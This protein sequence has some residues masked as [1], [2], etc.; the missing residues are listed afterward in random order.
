M[1]KT[2]YFM[3]WNF[4]LWT[5]FFTALPGLPLMSQSACDYTLVMEDDFG[6]GWNGGALTI[7]IGGNSSVYTL[8]AIDDDGIFAQ[9]TLN[10]MNGDS[11][12]LFYLAGD[13][14]TEVQYTLFDAQ[15]LIVFQDGLGSTEPMQGVVY[16]G[17]IFCPTCFPVMASSV[18]TDE[19]RAFRADIS[20]M[21]PGLGGQYLIEYDTTGFTPGGGNFQTASGAGATLF[22]LEENTP[23]DFYITTLCTN[24][25]TSITVGPFSFHTLYANDVAI[26]G[27]FSPVSACGLNAAEAISVAITNFGGVPQTLIPFDFSVNGIPGGVRMP[28]DGF[29]T[30]VIGTDSTEITEF[31]VLFDFSDFAEYTLQVWT[32]L[33]G[34]SVTSN[35]TTTVKIVNIPLIAEYPYFEGFEEWGGGWTVDA[36]GFGAPSWEYGQP[37]G[38]LIGGAANGAGAWVTNLEGNYNNN[39]ISYLISPCLDFSSLS[40]DPRIA[41][42][43]FVQTENNFD[44]AWLEV[45]TDGGETWSKVGQAGAGLNWYNDAANNWWE[46]NGAVAGWHYAQNI[47]QGT[48]GAADVRARFVFSSDGSV[49][50]EGIGLDNMLIGPVSDYDLAAASVAVGAAGG[51][52]SPNDTVRINLVNLGSGSADTAVVAYSVNGGSPVVDTITNLALLPGG[53][54]AY[55]FETTFDASLA[56][57]YT[58]Q[59]WVSFGLDEFLLNDTVTTFYQTSYT[60]PFREDFESGGIPTGWATSPGVTVAQEHTS[61][62]FVIFDY[63]WLGTTSMEVATPAIGPIE[64]NDTLT[65]DYRYVDYFAGT[66]PTILGLEDSLVVEISIDCGETFTP[67]FVINGN[68]HLPSVS[69]RTV[70]LPLGALTGEIIIIRFRAVWGNGDYYLDLDN[71]NV[72]RCPESLQLTAELTPPSSSSSEDG[73]ITIVAG[74]PSGPFTYLWNTGDATK[75]LTNLAEGVY[76]VTVT[77]VYGCSETL[78]VNLSLNSTRSPAHIGNISLAPNPTRGASV[79]NVEFTKPVDARMQL[80]NTMGQ[81]L[82]ET[83]ERNVSRGAYE[84]DLSRY[85]SGLYLVRIIAEGEVK[86]VKLIKAG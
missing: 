41:F 10:V 12:T 32:A 5:L 72:R 14:P 83:A 57:T 67:A 49:V 13:Y 43:L 7:T 44:E 18:S 66:D 21:P 15:G 76:T 58:I 74:D 25:D 84:L 20:W 28:E 80:L 48:A 55:T 77:N 65:F 33:E 42:S 19:V 47:L 81:L 2:I 1:T 78:E 22:N 52:G 45:S 53:S 40:E 64:E 36:A 3:K 68:N 82:F 71:I 61:P 70:E 63:L 35:D 62:S 79:L 50:R 37:S 16:T 9:L 17:A 85:N 30:G 34:D 51:C 75:T 8:N 23:Y 39:E 73:S 27:V 11:I 54:V 31:D 56:G 38:G 60:A 24:G 59:S 69:L 26:T 46:N 29:F 6:D 4:T 86:T